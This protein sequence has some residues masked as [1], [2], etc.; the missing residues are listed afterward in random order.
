MKKIF[1]TALAI[2]SL[3]FINA[4]TI[5]SGS[6]S[7]T[8]YIKS[9]GTIQKFAVD[10]SKK[11]HIVYDY[12]AALNNKYIRIGTVEREQNRQILIED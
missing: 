1:I 6:R 7:T 9:D 10:K 12:N 4:Q 11:T 2:S 3:S 5:Q 8:G